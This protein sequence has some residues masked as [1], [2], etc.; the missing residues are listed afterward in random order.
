M[1]KL[2]VLSGKQLVKALSKCGFAYIRTTGS[3]A[4]LMREIPKKVCISVPLHPELSKGVLL[5]ILKKAE[6]TRE[7]LEQLTP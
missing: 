2:P 5:S 3:H 6:I 4:V 1:P 7:E